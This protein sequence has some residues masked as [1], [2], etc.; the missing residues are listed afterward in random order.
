MRRIAAASGMSA[1]GL[2]KHFESK[3]AMFSA[4]VDPVL[5]EMRSLYDDLTR[6]ENDALSDPKTETLWEDGSSTTVMLDYIYS[7]LDV[8]KLVIC[9]SQGTKY[10]D[11]VHDCAVMEEQKTREFVEEA[12]KNGFHINDIPEE[13]F[14]LLVTMNINAI[15]AAVEHDFT[16]EQ[17]MHYAK[18]LEKFFY[19]GWREVL[20]I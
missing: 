6:Q 7:H 9:A 19:P 5:D 14:H 15:V 20:G 4:I 12:R 8:F 2:Y 17:A 3:E 18:T 11:F 13:E 10:A 16:R 1:S